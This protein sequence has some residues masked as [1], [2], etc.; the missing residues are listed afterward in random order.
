MV[1]AAVRCENLTST[2]IGRN[3][4]LLDLTGFGPW[5]SGA[6]PSRDAPL[7]AKAFMGD[8]VVHNLPL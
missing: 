3:F 2:K 7:D 8:F 1:A 6:I 4:G 5:V